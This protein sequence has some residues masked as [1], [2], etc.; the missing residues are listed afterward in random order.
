[1]RDDPGFAASGARQYQK[2]PIDMGCCFAL[3]GVQTL[4]EIHENKRGTTFRIARGSRLNRRAGNASRRLSRVPVTE[5]DL[6]CVYIKLP[7]LE[8]APSARLR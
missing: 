5:C 3:L 4:E 1:V 8:R 6:A 7:H 2:R